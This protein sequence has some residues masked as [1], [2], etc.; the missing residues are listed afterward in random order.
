[1][2]KRDLVSGMAM[3][4]F[5]IAMLANVIPQEIVEGGDYTISPALLPQICAIGITALSA[6]LVAKAIGQLRKEPGRGMEE[7]EESRP[8]PWGP[9][10]FAL[11]TVAAAVAIFRLVHPGLAAVFLVLALM[12]YMGERRWYLL[13]ALPLSLLGVGYVLFYEILGMVVR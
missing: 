10:L 1:M 4:L 2:A 13:A 6:L 3:F 12:L 8:M 11:T 7:A 5:G 9:A